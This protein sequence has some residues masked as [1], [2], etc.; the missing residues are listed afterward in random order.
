MKRI[1]TC[2]IVILLHGSVLAQ[3]TESDTLRFGYRFNVNGSWITGNVERLLITNNLDLSH[4]GKSI[5]VKSSNNY[6]YGTIYGFKTENDIFSRNFVYLHP[7]RRIYP[8]AMLWVQSSKRQQI[9][10]RYQ[11][12]LGASISVIQKPNHQLKISTTLS[13]E[14]TRYQGT[15]FNIEPENLKV[16]EVSNWRGTVRL[17]GNHHIVNNKLILKYETWYQPAFD[18]A[19]NWRYFIQTALEIPLS[20]HFSFRSA[21]IYSHEN[22]VLSTIKQDD[23]ILTF[24]LNLGNF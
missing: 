9:D 12:G 8:Y 18:D 22:I 15:T 3:L 24:G 6:T 19:N 5:G 13:Q 11:V 14:N 23:K 17:L 21:L 16:D 20:R 4:I 7:K 1:F 2:C 10:F